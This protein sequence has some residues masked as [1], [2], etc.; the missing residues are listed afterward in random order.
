VGG[1]PVS[2][3]V[4]PFTLNGRTFCQVRPLSEAMGATVSWDQGAQ[5]V[6][7]QRE[8]LKA[9]CQVGSEVGIV[10]DRPYL[11]EDPPLFMGADSVV[12]PVRFISEALGYQVSWNQMAQQVNL[13]TN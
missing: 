12:V 13:T 1:R 11:L 8:S 6:T 2:F 4:P 10:N 9:Q 7:I 5:M 3:D